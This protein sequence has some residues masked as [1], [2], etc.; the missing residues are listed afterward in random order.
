MTSVWNAIAKF[1]NCYLCKMLSI[2]SITGTAAKER[3]FAA[4]PVYD[5]SKHGCL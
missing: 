4:V 3:F 2:T 1:Y 5:I